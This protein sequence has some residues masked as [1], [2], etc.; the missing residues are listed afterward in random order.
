[1]SNQIEDLAENRCQSLIGP[2][3][4]GKTESI[5]CAL[6]NSDGRQL[7]LT[8]THAGVRSLRKKFNKFKIPQ[9][10]YVLE[11][12]HGFFLKYAASYPTNS[13]RSIKGTFAA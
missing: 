1:M 9:S 6:Q 13:M 7:V 11:T 4:S 8:H 3:G 10:K 2:A 12:I 5:A